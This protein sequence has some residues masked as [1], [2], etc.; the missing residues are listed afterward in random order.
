MLAILLKKSGCWSVAKLPSKTPFPLEILIQGAAFRDS[1]LSAQRN[2]T[3]RAEFFN[4][5]LAVTDQNTAQITL[6][7]S[8]SRKCT[9]AIAKPLFTL[10]KL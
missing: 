5:I 2:K 9:T 10:R 6:R 1:I 3:R 7:L 4:R 8:N